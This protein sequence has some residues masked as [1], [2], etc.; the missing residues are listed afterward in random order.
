MLPDLSGFEITIKKPY[1]FIGFTCE[2]LLINSTFRI[3]RKL[4][5]ALMD[6]EKNCALKFVSLIGQK[7]GYCFLW[8]WRPKI[9]S[10]HENSEYHR[11]DVF[12][13]ALKGTLRRNFSVRLFKK[14]TK[15]Y[16]KSGNACQTFLT[17]ILTQNRYWSQQKTTLY[18]RCLALNQ[19]SLK[20]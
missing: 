13:Q 12:L 3:L 15:I 9:L 20:L 16:W 19:I 10:K 4:R 2:L 7:F 8:S 11:N 14:D 5:S 17:Q 6:Y 18:T 1:T